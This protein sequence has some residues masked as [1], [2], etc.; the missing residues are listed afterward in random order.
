MAGPEQRPALRETEGQ[1]VSVAGARPG[2]GGGRTVQAWS[3]CVEV[4]CPNST[5]TVA[6]LPAITLKATYMLVPSSGGV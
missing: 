5:V 1:W 4:T 3:L 2:R 6:V